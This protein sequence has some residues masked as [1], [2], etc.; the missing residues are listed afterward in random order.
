M[1]LQNSFLFYFSFQCYKCHW[2]DINVFFFKMAIKKF[3]FLL[4]IMLIEN[5]F[6]YTRTGVY[7]SISCNPLCNNTDNFKI[8]FLIKKI[9]WKKAPAEKYEIS[10]TSLVNHPKTFGSLI[11]MSRISTSVIRISI[12]HNVVSDLAPLSSE[13]AFFTLLFPTMIEDTL[14]HLR[15][16]FQCK[17]HFSFAWHLRDWK[18]LK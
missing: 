6:L 10:V 15:L 3:P 9:L 2:S 4:A 18:I 11:F 13:L 16:Y 7:Y 1:F 14:F 8:S 12:F 5:M 17:K